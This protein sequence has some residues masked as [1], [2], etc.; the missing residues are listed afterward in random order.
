MKYCSK[1]SF[2]SIIFK[3][4]NT[5]VLHYSDKQNKKFETFNNALIQCTKKF[6]IMT[7]RLVIRNL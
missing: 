2:Q 6:K 7:K 4:I 1:T 3:N 5:G